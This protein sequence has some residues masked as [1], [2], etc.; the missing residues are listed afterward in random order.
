MNA[1]VS[2]FFF[3]ESPAQRV[4]PRLIILFLFLF[5]FLPLGAFELIITLPT[6]P[7]VFIDFEDFIDIVV[8]DCRIEVEGRPFIEGVI[9][10]SSLL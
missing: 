10:L 7:T 8:F 2:V 1:I 4:A 9:L 6:D 3:V 5:S